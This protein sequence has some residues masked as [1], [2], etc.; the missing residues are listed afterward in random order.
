MPARSPSRSSLF[1]ALL[2]A[3]PLSLAF[4]LAP[5]AADALALDV[6]LEQVGC[7]DEFGE[8]TCFGS[9]LTISLRLTNEG[10]LP[11]AGLGVSAVGYDL[12]MINFVNGQAVD[13]VLDSICV[14]GVD[15]FGGLSNSTAPSLSQSLANPLGPEV[16]I[17]NAVAVMPVTNDG[18]IDV[19]L[20]G[21]A[22]GPHAEL[23]FVIDGPGTTEIAI[24]AFPE[25]GDGII[26]GGGT[27]VLPPGFNQ[28]VIVNSESFAYVVP[29]PGTATLVG[30]GLAALAGA[31]RRHGPKSGTRRRPPSRA[32][33]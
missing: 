17:L 6:S 16:Q 18:S 15:C 23:R 31:S 22:G 29:E 25:Y 28:R 9:T 24:G 2:L 4:A 13:S 19:G 20:D 11:I 32:S 10:Q 33:S 26:L 21:L 14:P 27:N 8:F 30:L 7:G 12:S 3:A 1:S 5:R